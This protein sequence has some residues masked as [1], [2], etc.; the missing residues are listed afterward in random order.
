ME[1]E[2]K[3]E[4]AENAE[5]SETNETAEPV[6]YAEPAKKAEPE[7]AAETKDEDADKEKNGGFLTESRV[8][9]L[10]AIFLGITALLTAWATWIGSLHGG[11][12]ATNYTKSNNLA[13]E[14]NSE[15]NMAL[16]SYQADLMAWN[17]IMDYQFDMA[18]AEYK[19]Q[20]EEVEFI[21]GK[22]EDFIK[23]NLSERLM[24][25]VDWLD[26]QTEKS[27]AK[28]NAVVPPKSNEEAEGEDDAE[29]DGDAEDAN[30]PKDGA[31]KKDAAA[32]A[33][34]PKPAPAGNEEDSE[35][36]ESP[37][38]MPGL[39]E[40]YFEDANKLLEESQKLLDEGQRDNS[41]GD[42]FNLVNVIYSVVLFLLGI[43]GVFKKI[44]N[45][46]VLLFISVV[47]LVIAT[48]YMLTLPMPTGFDFG[49]FFASKG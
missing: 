43:V 1:E 32:D 10:V 44:P 20:K 15:Y 36:P 40:S 11:N 25:G 3:T 6:K 16:Q 29:E 39:M 46:V 27:P 18:M 9:I 19:G 45:R 14:G 23:N 13:A 28:A 49:S 37:F 33:Q 5:T 35:G 48:I 8:E 17:R 7:K 4:T 26:Q 24:K 41:N 42:A 30:A 34:A 47:I 38:E 31:D 12:Q 21:E 2:N 22:F